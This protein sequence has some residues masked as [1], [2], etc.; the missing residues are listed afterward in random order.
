[1]RPDI[2]M[3]YD[4]RFRAW[5]SVLIGTIVMIAG[6]GGA[7]VSSPWWL[8]L[9]PIGV[10]SIFRLETNVALATLADMERWGVPVVVLGPRFYGVLHGRF[11]RGTTTLPQVSCFAE[12]REAPVENA[13]GA[14]PGKPDKLQAPWLSLVIADIASVDSTSGEKTIRLGLRDRIEQIECTTT[15]ERDEVLKLLRPACAWSV[16][17]TRR[18]VFRIDLTSWIFCLPLTLFAATIALTAVGLVQPQQMPLADWNDIG[19]IR[20]K[21]RGLAVLWVLASQAYR[22]VVEHCPPVVAGVV[23]LVGTIAF[24]ALLATLQWPCLTDETWTNPRPPG[25]RDI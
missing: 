21:G 3:N 23:G 8:L 10:T 25:A 24:G 18:K 19:G 12:G 14:A 13:T 1:M 11:C 20:G 5:R 7:S 2:S 4:I 15:Y 6:V 9:L 17:T 22:F 16:E